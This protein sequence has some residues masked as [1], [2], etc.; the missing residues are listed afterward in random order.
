MLWIVCLALLT[1]PDEVRTPVSGTSKRAES[2]NCRVDC[3][4]PALDARVIIQQCEA[5]RSKLLATWRPDEEH[6]AWSVPCQVVVHASRASYLAAVGRGGQTSFGS[7]W[8]DFAGAAVSKRR[9][10]LLPDAEGELTAL[11]HE[12]THV[13]VADCFGGKQLPRWADEG[14]AIL[15]DHPHK[16]R[17]HQRDLQVGLAQQQ[18]FSCVELLT[19]GDYPPAGRIPAFYGQSASVVALLCRRK[20][21]AL[22]VKFVQRSLQVGNPTA[23]HEVYGLNGLHELEQLWRHDPAA[24]LDFHGV[25]LAIAP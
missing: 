5:W 14:M 23:L 7:T 3:H 9:I 19:L 16:R 8:I 4:A 25:H 10:D 18:A 17:L 2:H 12:M 15:A 22:F 6:K 1:A 21:P 20:P 13:V 11:G 24:A